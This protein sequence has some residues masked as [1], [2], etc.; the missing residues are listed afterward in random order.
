MARGPVVGAALALMFI[1][2]AQETAHAGGPTPFAFVSIL[3]GRDVIG[4]GL[5]EYPC[6]TAQFAETY[7]V[8][9]GG[10]IY[11]DDVGRFGAPSVFTALEIAVEKIAGSPR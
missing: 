9:P 5:R 8:R 10:A 6:R 2:A 11:V 3:E 7:V 1:G 4:C